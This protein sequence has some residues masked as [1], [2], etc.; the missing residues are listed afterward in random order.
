MNKIHV[1]YISA[2]AELGGA[3]F[4]LFNLL[5]NVGERVEPYVLITSD[6]CE[7]FADKVR[8][9][10][11]QS[12]KV[13]RPIYPWLFRSDSQTPALDKLRTFRFLKN[14]IINGIIIR[15]IIRENKIDIVHTNDENIVDSGV[16]AKMASCP[17]VW[18]MRSRLGKDGFMKHP[19]GLKFSC[20]V[21]EFL[22][23]AVIANS[24]STIGPLMRYIKKDKVSLI[25]NGID[26]CP[27][28]NLENGLT[29]RY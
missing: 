18:H 22:S 16:G 3:V 17:H 15:D 24:T 2:A 6:Q 10:G 26:T 1:L 11:Y 20:N 14:Q 13:D 19:F 29:E 8:V 5:E 4:S 9:L 27:V 7:E 23:S 28:R 25:Y 21:I 12:I